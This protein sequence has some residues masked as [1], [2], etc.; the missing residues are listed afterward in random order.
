MKREFPCK[1]VL[2]KFQQKAPKEFWRQGWDDYEELMVTLGAIVNEGD[3]NMRMFVDGLLQRENRGDVKAQ[4][5]RE[6]QPS[7]FLKLPQSS[8]PAPSGKDI[9]LLKEFG[10]KIGQLPKYDEERVQDL[11]PLF[12][13][14]LCF[15]AKKYKGEGKSKKEARQ[16]AAHQACG[17]LRIGADR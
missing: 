9:T 14:I 6:R 16:M 11:P 15:D 3:E 4:Y 10:N 2:I 17:E 12:R 13:S 7:I 1:D 8:L 5:A